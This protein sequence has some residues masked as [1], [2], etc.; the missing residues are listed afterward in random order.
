MNFYYCIT[1]ALEYKA[2]LNNLF[3]LLATHYLVMSH[4]LRD[5]LL[6]SFYIYNEVI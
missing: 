5:L 1:K 3:V 6:T 4:C 2:I